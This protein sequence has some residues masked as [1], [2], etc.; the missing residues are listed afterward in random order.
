[1]RWDNGAVVHGGVYFVYP[2]PFHLAEGSKA[3]YLPYS[4][5]CG[6]WRNREG[7]TDYCSHS[8]SG[9]D[10]TTRFHVSTHCRG[11]FS[12]IICLLVVLLCVRSGEG[13]LCCSLQN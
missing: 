3:Y 10:T 7:T 5:M 6:A 4:K 9:R 2:E 12:I 1:M 8:S 11:K 13:W